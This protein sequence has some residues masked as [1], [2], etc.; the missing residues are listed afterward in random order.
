MKHIKK[1]LVSALSTLLISGAY[2]DNLDFSVKL[3][4]NANLNGINSLNLQSI[5]SIAKLESIQKQNN[6][7]VFSFKTNNDQSMNLKADAK[8]SKEA[9][10]FHKA[11]EITRALQ[12]NNQIEY[13]VYRGVQMKALGLLSPNVALKDSTISGSSSRWN[14]QWDMHGPYSVH[15]DTAW[16]LIAGKNLSDVTVAITDTGIAPNAP[17]DIKNRVIHGLYFT[18]SGSE[19]VSFTTDPTDHGSFHGTHV[20]GTIGAVGPVVK[21]VTAKADSVELVAVKVL[22]DNG[23][24]S[25]DAVDAG[26]EW[27]VGANAGYDKVP[28]NAPVNAHPAQVVNLSLGAQ[29]QPWTSQKDWNTF[30]EEYCKSWQYVVDVAHQHNATLVIA[31]GNGNFFGP[32]D[33]AESLP[34]GCTNGDSVVVSATGPKGQMAFY[35]NTANNAQTLGNNTSI[36]APGGNDST[37]NNKGD[38]I[39]STVD[40]G[41]GFM[42]GTS[43]ATPHV[44]GVTALI[45]ATHPGISYNEVQVK[46]KSSETDANHNILDASVAVS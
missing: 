9:I 8:E 13:A 4:D 19:P 40:N 12:K 6:H 38:E 31:A 15:A 22:G 30:S 17:N 2:A 14:E 1:L 20:A 21:G 5:E 25:F 7:Y 35:S 37:G 28:N 24:G 34:A 43:M 36:T 26:V 42:Q 27:A 3:K 23:S 45:Y 33:I 39:L 32:T 44:A 11:M 16:N 46:L 18:Q 41:Y 10:D 29:K